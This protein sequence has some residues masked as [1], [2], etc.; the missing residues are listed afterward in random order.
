MHNSKKEIELLSHYNS[1]PKYYSSITDNAFTKCIAKSG[2]SLKNSTVLDIGCGDARL[3]NKLKKYDISHYTGIDYSDIRISLAKQAFN[4]YNNIELFA[5]SIQ[6]F[7]SQNN[8]HF[9]FIFSFEFFEHLEKPL[10]VI[11]ELKKISYY[12]IGSVP[13]NMPYKAH[14]QIYKNKE[15]AESKLGCEV[16][17]TNNKHFFFNIKGS[18]P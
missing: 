13:I 14:L 1:N 15:Q 8:T 12:I 4:Q 10:E 6:D 16:L 5:C 2:I 11:S 17:F 7:I 18:Q 3:F 9:D